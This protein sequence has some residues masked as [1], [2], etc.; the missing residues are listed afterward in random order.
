MTEKTDILVMGLPRNFH[1]GPGMGSN[2]IL[3]GLAISGQL[4][5]CWNAFKEG[6]VVI[7]VAVCDG[8]FN[9]AWFPSYE[10]TYHKWQQYTFT[11]DFLASKDA[12]QIAENPE[13]CYAYSNRYTYHPFHAMSMISGASVVPNRTQARYIVGAQAPQFA[14]GL[15][16][17][18]VNTLEQAIADAQR[19]VGTNPSILCTPEAFSGGVG[20]HLFAQG[21]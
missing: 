5:R 21:D 6:G 4:S 17:T 12:R 10:E 16:Y 8:W 7:A 13:Y 3:M 15:Q 14:R 20:V 1:Y 9:D 19:Y 18:P 11:E 2:P